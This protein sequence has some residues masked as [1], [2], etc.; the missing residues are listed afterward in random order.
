MK[1]NSK[2]IEGLNEAPSSALL[3]KSPDEVEEDPN[4]DE[5]ECCGPDPVVALSCDDPEDVQ[6]IMLRGR[7][8]AWLVSAGHRPPHNHH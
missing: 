4:G 7:L 2:I 3:G 8:Y 1:G 6:D 5:G